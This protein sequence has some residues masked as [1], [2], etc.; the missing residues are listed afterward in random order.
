[1]DKRGFEYMKQG[2]K[3]LLVCGL[4]VMVASCL[5]P[6]S[7]EDYL[8]KFEKFVNRV[9]ENHKHYNAKD[10]DWA[11]SQFKKY[12]KE[13]YPDFKDEFTLEDQIKIKAFI[14]EY[15]SYKNKQ[16]LGDL[17]R[18]LFRD[19]ANE[20]G[21]KVEEYIDEDFDEDLEKI[22]EGASAIGDSAVKVLEDVIDELGRTF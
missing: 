4:M 13:W 10:W 2:I 3:Y 19:D 22:I 8:E 14:I 17:L 12:N 1:M 20:I 16:G 7:K 5:T 11:D 18:D 15:H 9:E 21:G 6:T